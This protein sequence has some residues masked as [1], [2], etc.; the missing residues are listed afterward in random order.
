MGSFVRFERK[1]QNGVSLKEQ[2]LQVEKSTGKRPNELNDIVPLPEKGKYLWKAF[3]DLNNT[4]GIT[5]ISGMKTL[6]KE[7]P[8]TYTELHHYNEMQP[9]KF[10]I[11]E[12]NII[13]EI[14]D[15]YIKHINKWI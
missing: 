5:V 10:T 15:E 1:N 11:N 14:D 2:L 3:L 8:I 7:N 12:L 9:I 6:L 13:K 4:R